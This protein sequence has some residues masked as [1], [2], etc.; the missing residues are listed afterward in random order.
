MNG[1]GDIFWVFLI[2]SMMQPWLRQ[3]M[4]DTARVRLMHKIEK[5]R[6]SQANRKRPAIPLVPR[7]GYWRRPFERPSGTVEARGGGTAWP[8]CR[9]G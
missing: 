5:K 4:L 9:R 8:P 2:F 3:K 6:G 7:A 1:I